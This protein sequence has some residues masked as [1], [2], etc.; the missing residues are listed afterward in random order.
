MGQRVSDKT[1]EAV[2]KA[3]QEHLADEYPGSMVT[4]WVAEVSHQ[5]LE[6]LSLT[7]YLYIAPLKQAFHIS[8][9]LSDIM[10]RTVDDIWGED[11]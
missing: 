2:E 5:N 11:E 9:G 1:R 3:L 10:Q 8:L 7:G 6:D 4:G